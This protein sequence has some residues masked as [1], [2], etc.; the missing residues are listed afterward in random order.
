MVWGG[1]CLFLWEQWPHMF[2]LGAMGHETLW[3]WTTGRNDLW[4]NNNG[5]RTRRG[6]SWR[7]HSRKHDTWWRSYAAVGTY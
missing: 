3:E 7:R 5:T 1:G 2:R 4:G 6:H